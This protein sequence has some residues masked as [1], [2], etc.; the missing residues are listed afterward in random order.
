[1]LLI[2]CLPSWN[3]FQSTWCAKHHLIV[4]F[5][6]LWSF[7]RDQPRS[8]RISVILERNFFQ[9]TNNVDVWKFVLTHSLYQ[10]QQRKPIHLIFD[11]IGKVFLNIHGSCS[12]HWNFFLRYSARCPWLMMFFHRRMWTFR[13]CYR[14]RNFL[15]DK[16][17]LFFIFNSIEKISLT[18]GVFFSCCFSFFTPINSRLTS[19]ATM[20]EML[21]TTCQC[22]NSILVEY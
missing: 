10:Y 13:R 18:L 14:Q 4:K 7:V 5:V 9:R 21:F 20:L 3:R 11:W 16:S 2:N 6:T 8:S 19:A 12:L 1:M 22:L 17:S 15:V